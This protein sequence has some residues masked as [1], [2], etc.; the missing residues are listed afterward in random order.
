M[1]INLTFVEINELV[2]STGKDMAFTPISEGCFSLRYNAG[3]LLPTINIRLRKISQC[4]GYIKFAYY[5]ENTFLLSAANF[6]S[7]LPE[8]TQLDTSANSITIYPD[9][10]IKLPNLTKT[11]KLEVFDIHTGSVD[12]SVS[13]I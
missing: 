5:S 3:G 2:K 8:G 12:I 6:F 10:L 9:K 11:V 7:F 1:R 13:L 4:P